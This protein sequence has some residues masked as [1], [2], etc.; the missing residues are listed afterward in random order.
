M[1]ITITRESREFTEVEKYLMTVSPSITSL[2]DVP[3]N[4]HIMVDGVLEFEDTKEEKDGEKTDILSIITP[5][6]KVYS[7]Q[8]ATLKR[9]MHDIEKIMSGKKFGIIKISGTT[10]SGRPYINCVL[11]IESVS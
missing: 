3:D 1:A 10:K 11:D 6:K 4:E 7:C 2:K 5:D 9:S 8:S